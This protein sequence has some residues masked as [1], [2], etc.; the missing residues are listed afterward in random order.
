M[1]NM[2]ILNQNLISSEFRSLKNINLDGI[3]SVLIKQCQELEQD[4]DENY[5]DKRFTFELINSFN[6]RQI[7]PNNVNDIIELCNYLQIDKTENFIVNNCEPSYKYK[8]DETYLQDLGFPTFITDFK[9]NLKTVNKIVT[10]GSLNWLNYAHKVGCPWN[11]NICACAA[12]SDLNCL[13]YLHE[14]NCP[15]DI[16]TC[17]FA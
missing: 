3:E 8:I 11:E 13:K 15:W 16:I 12:F 7:N 17:Q 2:D 6:E 1:N 14:N 10:Y 9:K 5:I 4:I